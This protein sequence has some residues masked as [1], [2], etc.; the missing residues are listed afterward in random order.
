MKDP[1]ALYR[2]MLKARSDTMDF[3]VTRKPEPGRTLSIEAVEGLLES[4]RLWLGSR[5]ARDL[6][7]R[8]KPDGRVGAG[9]SEV[10][11]TMKVT[12]DGR[13]VEVPDD[14]YPWYVIDGSQRTR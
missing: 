4:M 12:I 8:L 9:P 14:E 1:E 11:V 10:K 2:E 3:V 5:L 6:D 7:V 13:S